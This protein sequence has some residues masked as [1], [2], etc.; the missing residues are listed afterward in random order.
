MTEDEAKTKWCPLA[1]RVPYASAAQA[2]EIALNGIDPDY[3]Q[4]MAAQ[5]PC[6]ASACMA[7]RWSNYKLGHDLAFH[8]RSYGK[9]K[10]KASHE[11]FMRETPL[12]GYCGLAGAP[13]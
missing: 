5:W 2:E 4:D 10:A 7:W 9:E 13:Q 6:I 12:N 1:K 11:Q 3:S 8:E